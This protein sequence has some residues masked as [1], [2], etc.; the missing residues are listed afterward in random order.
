[1]RQL[2]IFSLLLFAFF[3]F[4]QNTVNISGIVKDQVTGETLPGATVRL[5]GTSRGVITDFEGNFSLTLNTEL[6]STAILQVSY[7]GYKATD[8]NVNNNLRLYVFMPPDTETLDEVVVT[9]S[10]GTKKPREEVV[11]S[12]STLT[13]IDIQSEQSF[14]SFEKIIEGQVAG[15]LLNSSTEIGF[16]TSINIRGQGSLTPLTN[17]LGTST[18][19]LFIV[20]GVVLIEDRGF[21]DTLFDGDGTFGNTF[22]NPLARIPADEIESVSVLKD[23]A[24]VGIYGADAAN[25][26]IL[27]TT[28]RGRKGKARFNIN[29]R[30]GVSEGINRIK[31][32]SGEQYNE[33]L[34]TFNV[35][36]ERGP[37]VPFNGN[38]VDWFEVLNGSG[39]FN[40]VNASVSGG[41]KDD[42]SYRLGFNYQKN[43]EA[44]LANEFTTWGVTANFDKSFNKLSFGLSSKFSRN[45]RTAPND[46]FNFI[47]AP[48]FAIFDENG[49]YTFTGTNGIPNPLAAIEQNTDESKISSLISSFNVQYNVNKD[50]QISSIFGI[51]HSDKDETLWLSGANESGRRTGSFDV[52]GETFPNWGRSLIRE[53]EQTRWNWS[54][55]SFYQKDLDSHHVDAL[56]GFEL[57]SDRS[58]NIRELGTGYVDPTFYQLPQEADGGLTLDRLTSEQNGRSFF[59]QINYDFQKKYFLLGNIRRDESSAFGNDKNVAWNGGLGASWVLSKE[60]FLSSSAVIDFF[61]LR[62]SWGIVGNSR[63]GSFRSSGLYD[64]QQ[65]GFG[66]LDTAAPVSSAPPNS[67]LGWEV[68]EKLSVGLDINLFNFL[69][70][71]TDYFRDERRDMIVSR[72]VPL[73]TGFTNAEINGASMVNQGLELGVQT[74]VN[75]ERFRWTSNFTLATLKNEVTELSGL[76][77]D[78]S[79]AESARAQRIGSSTSTLWG[80]P[81][82]GIDPAT[83]RNLYN[84]NGN[85]IDGI[86]LDDI[87]DETDW[88][89]LGDSNP[90]VYGG[91][92]NQFQFFNDFS[93]SFL[94]NYKWGQDILIDDERIN[95]YRVLFNRNMSV[96]VLDYWE[97][98]GDI[99]INPIPIDDLNTVSNSSR[100]LFD[101]TYIKLQSISLGYD[102]PLEMVNDLRLSLNATN[103]AYWYRSG[104]RPGRN[105]VRQLRF[106]YPEMRTITLGVNCTF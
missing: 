40:Q 38:D 66:L 65:T 36:S 42:T 22:L 26:V 95:Q 64:I 72:D 50:L 60:D 70:I 61:R 92:S 29:V 80:F 73:E 21:D 102:V 83:G 97:Q 8:V 76:G 34:N 101:E 12:I 30:S 84:I 6:L 24:A 69:K 3:A 62:A 52:N 85:I 1:M 79:N 94:I 82:V 87:T 33:L 18:Q 90:D 14:E 10:Y 56:L 89:S 41:F 16:P 5:K 13:A 105:G 68:N 9:S 54:I 44:Q 77:D 88:V 45:N 91:W 31:Y 75:N 39:T 37:A 57:R 17:S 55:Q 78:F 93:F 100:Y 98:Q 96:N 67:N 4:S 74:E 32:L 104:N 49:D 19:P 71:T 48:T 20:D 59:S 15:L 53:K 7:V 25:G 23:A 51:D 58:I 63:I 106:A 27:I 86:I 99:A 47:L 81:W 103:L 46:Y 2:L 35:N 11:G 28:K 43:D